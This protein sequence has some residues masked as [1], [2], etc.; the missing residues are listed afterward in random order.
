MNTSTPVVERE[1]PFLD[2]IKRLDMAL[3]SINSK[4]FSFQSPSVEKECGA[5]IKSTEFGD[6]LLVLVE[7]VE[8]LDG[9]IEF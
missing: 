5:K 2:L 7:Y 6:A 3:C 4:T 9:R 1:M 8:A